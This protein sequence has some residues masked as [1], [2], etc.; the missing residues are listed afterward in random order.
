MTKP[1]LKLLN[2]EAQRASG[3]VTTF[4]CWRDNALKLYKDRCTCAPDGSLTLLT[5][6]GLT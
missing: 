6:L 1:P 4:A 3:L 5:L 2:D